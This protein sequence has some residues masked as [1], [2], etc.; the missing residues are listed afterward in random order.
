MP[1]LS[2][3]VLGSL[4]ALASRDTVAQS[5]PIPV[6]AKPDVF[7][8]VT[9]NQWVKVDAANGARE[10][11]FDHTRLSGE[12][13]TQS[14]TAF[15]RTTLPFGDPSTRFIVKYDGE[16]LFTFGAL[17][18]EFVLAGEQW[19][20]DMQVEWDWL[21]NP[22]GDYE[23]NRKGTPPADSP[24]G[25]GTL[26][27][28]APRISPDG[29]WEALIESNNVVVRTTNAAGNTPTRL[30]TDGTADA[31]YHLGSISWSADS[32]TVSAFRVNSA[33]WTSGATT[34]L[35]KQFITKGQWNVPATKR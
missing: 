30:S 28:N 26:N 16:N 3:A 2:F 14:G 22:P 31:A 21:R 32:K 27:D 19:R 24:T 29:K 5:S 35:V 34:G 15:T 6:W 25:P 4:A 13:T 8:Y 23:C 17:A 33:V 20:C 1:R 10:L 12:L 11:L 18:L 7:W 9:N